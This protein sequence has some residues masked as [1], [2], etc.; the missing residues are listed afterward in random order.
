MEMYRCLE[1]PN[2]ESRHEGVIGHFQ[3]ELVQCLP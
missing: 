1:S 3:R 2:I